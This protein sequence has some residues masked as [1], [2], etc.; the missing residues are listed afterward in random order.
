MH[1]QRAQIEAQIQPLRTADRR[2]I[3]QALGVQEDEIDDA[4]DEDDAGS[5][6][7]ESLRRSR[8]CS[9]RSRSSS[10]LGRY[11]DNDK[12]LVVATEDG[13]D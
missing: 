6:D 12:R 5:G 3:A 1:A 2:R 4:E 9:A 11:A 7:G 8:S 10:A 13:D